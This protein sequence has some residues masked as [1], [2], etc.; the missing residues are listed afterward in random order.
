[1]LQ[2]NT[3]QTNFVVS[4]KTFA[5]KDDLKAMSGKW[6]PKKSCWNLPLNAGTPEACAA[7]WAKL[8]EAEKVEKAKR[9]EERVAEKAAA[10]YAASPEGKKAAVLLALANKTK[11]GA[12]HWVC[13]EHCQVINWALQHTSCRVHS[14]NDG[15][16]L[17]TF[18]VRGA[19]YTG[20]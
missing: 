17:N 15:Q 6:D 19:I 14:Q 11:T 18:R 12:Y 8:A 9:K 3:T 7:L 5:I 20:D 2:F 16:S 1:M 10:V 13:C 4:G